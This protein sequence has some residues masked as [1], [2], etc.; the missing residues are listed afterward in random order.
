MAANLPNGYA[1]A[2]SDPNIMKLPVHVEGF[3]DLEILINIHK[4]LSE[5]KFE[6]DRTLG[7][8]VKANYLQ[9]PVNLSEEKA[10]PIRNP[11]GF[12]NLDKA[13][14]RART[15]TGKAQ[16]KWP[17]LNKDWKKLSSTLIKNAILGDAAMG[18]VRPEASGGVR[19][20]PM[21]NG[22]NGHRDN[23]SQT[24]RS[25]A[26]LSANNLSRHQAR[27]MK[28]P[29]PTDR[30]LHQQAIELKAHRQDY[31]P[32]SKAN[33]MIGTPS[34]D[35]TANGTP[36]S[37]DG[38]RDAGSGKVR[39]PDGRYVNKDNPTPPERKKPNIKY[40]KKSRTRA[41]LG[42]ESEEIAE[43]S[44][45]EVG[46]F[47]EASRTIYNG[48]C[49]ADETGL[50]P[51]SP[52]SERAASQDSSEPPV[53]GPSAAAA[54]YEFP[55]SAI[56]AAEAEAVPSNLD[57]LPT[58]YYAHK[59]RKSESGIQR[60][61]SKRA[62][63]SR[64][65]VLGR[66]RKSETL[67]D[68]AKLE[69]EE[70]ENMEVEELTPQSTPQPETSASAPA[71]RSSR[72]S[73]A[74]ALESSTPWDPTG[75]VLF[76]GTSQKKQARRETDAPVN[77]TARTSD[78]V[79]SFT[80]SSI[81][82]K[83]TSVAKQAVNGGPPTAQAKSTTAQARAEKATASTKRVSFSPETYAEPSNMEFF[84]RITTAA[85][86]QEV[87]L[88][89]EDLTHEVDLVKKYAQW[90]DDGKDLVSFKTFKDI[91]KFSRTG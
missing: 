9:E 37:V 86:V 31:S 84:A 11:E 48:S 23:N 1:T 90:L 69:P 15:L 43:S 55:V 57:R 32:T 73:A 85:G 12:V 88:L 36:S 49:K 28:S 34:L 47:E 83:S 7:G 82:Q 71:R 63:G 52:Q 39:G 64:G 25:Q 40:V 27:E 66:P 91:S 81:N 70:V 3:I 24:P 2:G 38:P 14:R 4:C 8:W 67:L 54:T 21:S 26:S 53:R 13:Y 30:F 87:P 76:S 60:G 44:N 5:S 74:S 19:D 45:E 6:D 10:R 20:T 16:D 80:P 33:I 61:G 42:A 18:V 50:I 51:I 22:L 41:T 68:R 58:G 17:F 75:D 78:S 79:K 72:K 62:R 46:K 65:G 59:K 89:E 77:G 35:G 56:L 29:Q